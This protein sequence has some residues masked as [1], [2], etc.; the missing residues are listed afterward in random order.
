MREPS[1][2]ESEVAAQQDRLIL[3]V[4]SDH[5]LVIYAFYKISES[6]REARKFG[7]NLKERKS[8]TT[9]K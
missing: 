5:R 2:P 8:I 9:N 6:T 7:G 1:C 3:E 4:H